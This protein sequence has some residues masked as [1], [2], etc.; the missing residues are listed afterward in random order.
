MSDDC[1]RTPFWQRQPR[2]PLEIHRFFQDRMGAALRDP[3]ARQALV[4]PT[5]LGAPGLRRAHPEG[6]PEAELLNHAVRMLAALGHHDPAAAWEAHRAR[7]TDTAEGGPEGWRPAPA[8]GAWGPLVSL[9]CGWQLAALTPL[10]LGAQYPLACGV[11]LFNHG[12][13]HECHE[14]LESPWDAAEGE[15]KGQLQGLILLAGGY[16][17]LQQ[18]NL[19]G[20]V[21]LWEEARLRLEACRGHVRTP[22]GEV[23]AEVALDLTLRR[24]DHGRRM[25][26]DGDFSPLWTLDRPTWE[27]A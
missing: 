7:W 5:I 17:H 24:L 11:S 8:W 3:E 4:W 13:F 27:L 18:H 23:S 10:P 9:R 2:L 26:E 19:V 12:L 14:A 21:A 16:H 25:K 6:L 20:L 15:L 22:W 1:N